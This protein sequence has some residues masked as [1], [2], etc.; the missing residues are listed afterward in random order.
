MFYTASMVCTVFYTSKV[1][2]ELMD[3]C[4]H[5]AAVLFVLK[6]YLLRVILK[7]KM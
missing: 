6:F 5:Y 7:W 3:S 4:M 1:V 2:L